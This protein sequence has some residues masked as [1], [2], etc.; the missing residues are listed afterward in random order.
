MAYSCGIPILA[1]AER[2]LE[3]RLVFNWSV[4]LEI[5]S[6]PPNS[7]PGWLQTD[8]FRRPL[9]TWNKKLE[10]RRDIFLGYASSSRGLAL[11]IKRF[12]T[13]LQVSTLD[14]HDDFAP[15]GAFQTRLLKP[16]HD[17]AAAFSCLLRTTNWTPPAKARSHVTTW[18]LRLA[19]SSALK[20][21]T[22]FS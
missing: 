9:A 21:R 13:E 10:R 6:I 22:V 18:S 17:V 3:P 20:E 12:L 16:A 7:E 8:V 14:W 15:G 4:G 1:L 5:I 11:N 2:G 19:F